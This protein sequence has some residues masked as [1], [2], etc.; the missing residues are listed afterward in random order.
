MCLRP[1]CEDIHSILL[2]N[3]LFA[4]SPIRPQAAVSVQLLD[5][6]KKSQDNCTASVTGLAAAL[7]AHY[8]EEVR[9]FSIQHKSSIKDPFRRQ[10]IH[11]IQW[12]DNLY[13]L[14]NKRVESA[15]RDSKPNDRGSTAEVHPCTEHGLV[16]GRA[17]EFLI[18]RCPACFNL[19]SWGR[20]LSQRD[21]H[22]GMDGNRTHKHNTRAGDGPTGHD[23][24]FFLSR[25]TVDA[26]GQRIDEIRS[27]DRIH[28]DPDVPDE[29]IDQCAR[30][31]SAANEKPGRRPSEKFDE[32]GIFHLTCRH[33]IPLFVTS[34]T[35]EGEHHKYFA[36]LVKEVMGLLPD[37]ATICLYSDVACII[38]RSMKSFP[39]LPPAM[40]E[41]IRFSL[42]VLHCLNHAY[43][44]KLLYNPRLQ[45]GRGLTDGEF[46]E[47]VLSMLR[48]RITAT[49]SQWAARRIWSLEKQL[50]FIQQL[51]RSKL[52][53][54]LR[55]RRTDAQKKIDAAVQVL[56]ECGISIEQLRKEWL[57]EQ[58]AAHTTDVVNERDDMIAVE[59]LLDLQ[60]AFDQLDT[61]VR[62]TMRKT[63]SSS[64]SSSAKAM[65]PLFEEMKESLTTTK[66]KID[67][68][69]AAQMD[70][71]S[72]GLTGTNLDFM[73]MILMA[74]RLKMTVRKLA[75]SSFSKWQELDQAQGGGAVLA[76][77]NGTTTL[78]KIIAQEAPRLFAAIRK[79]NDLCGDI[80]KIAPLAPA[81]P[82]PTPLP[83]DLAGLRRDPNL[84]V[85]VLTTHAPRA[86]RD[87]VVR[88]GVDSMLMV[89]R[90]L[91]EH[92][93][94]VMEGTNIVEW[95]R[96]QLFAISNALHTPQ[97]SPPQSSL[98]FSALISF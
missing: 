68:I 4:C 10:V 7:S 78:R 98:A 61:K 28:Y 59:S 35:T 67:D 16:P 33:G 57:L 74:R 79:Y 64:S 17:N 75:A 76:G 19:K 71:S 65:N 97:C 37:K 60:V 46:V 29:A 87:P 80:I 55:Q 66:S 24:I 62:Q 9:V 92:A 14:I 70:Q 95:M 51:E 32:T 88:K 20:R 31:Y 38:E 93:R 89:D 56:R 72:L 42:N 82:L 91:E 22:L 41:R 27:G 43:L 90:C 47:R 73:R 48:N 69:Y 25:A 8:A 85:D 5:L 86:V 3:G 2:K 50:E 45:A 94:L 26:E 96:D 13:R 30:S 40:M 52:G 11:S 58:E 49:R 84:S 77:T 54:W 39:I 18:Q 34:M 44:C 53:Q 23:P 12:Y 6:W 15:L 63:S 81:F 36:T 83:T 21:V 1:G